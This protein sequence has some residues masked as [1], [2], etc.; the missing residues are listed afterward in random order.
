MR[1]GHPGDRRRPCRSI[2]QPCDDRQKR[3]PVLRH[4]WFAR[5]GVFTRRVAHV[6]QFRLHR[7]RNP[8]I[9]AAADR[10]ARKAAGR[11]ADSDDVLGGL[12]GMDDFGWAFIVYLYVPPDLRGQN[13]GARLI[14]DAEAI[15]R[16]RGMVGMWVN[17]F[18]FQAAGFYE[19]LGYARFGEL[20]KVGGA[21]GQIFLKKRFAEI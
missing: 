7:D 9:D 14:R 6:S 21:A 3:H 20:E 15:A 13:M 19:K 10:E 1:M 8:H 2:R 4:P 12:W 16:D 5:V 17:T 11:D 18:D